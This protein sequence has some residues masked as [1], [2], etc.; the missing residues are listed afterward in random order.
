GQVFFLHNRVMTIERMRDRIVYLCPAARVE[1]GHGR[2]DAEEL[3]AV[4]ARFVA[5]K[6]DVL[7]CTTIIESGLDIPNANTII[8]DRADRFGLADLYQLRGRV[9]RAEHKA[10]A[11]LLLPREMMTI[12]AARKRI[13]A[14][15]QY[16][17]LGAGFRIAMRDLEIRGAGSILGTAQSG[18]IMAVGFDLYCQLLKQAVAQR[19]G[20]KLRLR[21]DVDLRLNFVATNEAEFVHLG[22]KTCVPAFIPAG[23]IG[24]ATLRIQAYRRIAEITARDQAERL[25]REWR[26][27]FGQFPPAVDNLFLLTEIRLAAA[28]AGISRVEVREDKLMLTRRGDFILVG[29]KFPRLVAGRIE[30]RLRE[31]QELIKRL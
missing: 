1:I 2:M 5:G 10:Y 29:G 11:Y 7:V 19:K 8:I 24:E 12:G 14:I 17:S 16:S 15:K 3:E 9:G 20:E 31:I 21:L 13:N 4:M 30:Q 6:I 27:R 25:K 28:E 23:F 26:D 22:L 18:H